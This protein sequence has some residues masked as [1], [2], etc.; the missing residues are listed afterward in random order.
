MYVQLVQFKFYIMN[1]Q[2]AE[3]IKV[4]A[5]DNDLTIFAQLCCVF[6]FCCW[7]VFIIDKELDMLSA[8]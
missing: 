8:L 2:K 3:K 5:V 1:E 6:I 7:F 4:T